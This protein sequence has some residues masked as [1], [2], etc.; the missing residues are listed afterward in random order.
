MSYQAR[1]L[2]MI[3]CSV[4]FACGEDYQAEKN[5]PPED[6]LVSVETQGNPTTKSI[7]YCNASTKMQISMILCL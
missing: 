7:L 6:V 1:F 2:Y 5:T 4:L 3:S